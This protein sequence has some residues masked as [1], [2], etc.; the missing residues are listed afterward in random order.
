MECEKKISQ[1][2]PD[3]RIGI[4]LACPICRRYRGT[5]DKKMHNLT[6]CFPNSE[7]DST[8]FF[9]PELGNIVTF[10]NPDFWKFTN[11]GQEAIEPLSTSWPADNTRV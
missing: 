6:V 3:V 5:A 8:E 2:N 10:G 4:F 11:M 7:C 9:Q 1:K